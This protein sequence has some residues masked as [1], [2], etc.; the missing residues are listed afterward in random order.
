MMILAANSAVWFIAAVYQQFFLFQQNSAAETTE[1]VESGLTFLIVPFLL[2][3]TVI[4][5]VGLP[6]YMNY[7]K[8]VR[9][10]EKADNQPS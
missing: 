8:Q 10:K 4:I 7:R 6:F 2:A 1:K 5:V 9:P 3:L